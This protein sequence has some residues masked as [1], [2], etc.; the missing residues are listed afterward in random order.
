MRLTFAGLFQ[1]QPIFSFQ[2]SFQTLSKISKI[3]PFPEKFSRFL[4]AKISDDLF[5]VIDHKF[6]ISPYFPCFS[7][8]PPVWR[9]LLFSPTFKNFPSFRKIHLLFTYFMYISFPSY[10]DHDA[11]MHHPMH[12]LDAL[13]RTKPFHEKRKTKQGHYL[14]PT[15]CVIS[16]LIGKLQ[17]QTRSPF[18]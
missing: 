17:G 11:F 5:L 4:S 8:F 14:P 12:V 7:T 18:R 16:Q 3:L 6:R 1:I 13:G 2:K 9:K 15:N 10:F